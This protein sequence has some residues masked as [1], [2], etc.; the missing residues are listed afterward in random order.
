M[1]KLMTI[2]EVRVGDYV[3]ILPSRQEVKPHASKTIRVS[4]KS[5]SGPDSYRID[6]HIPRSAEDRYRGSPDPFHDLF[7]DNVPV[8]VYDLDEVEKMRK[9]GLWT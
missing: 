9:A 1:L 7:Y 6:G 3:T 4:Q 2:Q 8:I 5:L